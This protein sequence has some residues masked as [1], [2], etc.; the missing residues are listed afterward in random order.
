MTL[1]AVTGALLACS[2]LLLIRGLFPPP[3]TLASNLTLFHQDRAPT[4]SGRQPETPLA[5]FAISVARAVHGDLEDKER[6]LRVS[7]L[8]LASEAQDK[9]KAGVAVAALAFLLT[10]LTGLI[11][12]PILSLLVLGIGGIAG[13]LM[14]DAQLSTTAR[15]RRAEFDRTVNAF[16]EIVSVSVAGGA[17][18]ETAIRDTLAMGR[19]WAFDMLR[20]AVNESQLRGDTPWVGLE[21]LGRDIAV[22]SLIELAGAMSLASASG[23]RVSSTLIARAEASREKELANRLGEAEAKSETLGV[24]VVLMILGW[25]GFLGY[26][27]ILNLVGS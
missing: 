8:T 19:G 9:L 14:P 6:D 11:T 1:A 7:G 15:D 2:L 12:A 3:P 24:P 17:N 18:P 4:E 10:R 13:Y 23:A 25:S 20:V 5:R 16:L 26:P 22:D 21:A 27:A